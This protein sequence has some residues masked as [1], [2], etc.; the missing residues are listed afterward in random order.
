MGERKPVAE[1]NGQVLD[2]GFRVSGFLPEAD[3]ESELLNPET[4][5]QISFMILC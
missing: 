1:D 3:Q 5:Y 4:S 2:V